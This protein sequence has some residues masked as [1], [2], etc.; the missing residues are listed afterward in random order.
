MFYTAKL[1]R[2]HGSLSVKATNIEETNWFKFWISKRLLF[3]INFFEW[4]RFWLR[5]SEFLRQDADAVEDAED[6]RL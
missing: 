4:F 3:W 1:Y 6:G 5:S 2:P